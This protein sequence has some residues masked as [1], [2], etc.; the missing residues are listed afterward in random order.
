MILYRMKMSYSSQP[1]FDKE[2]Y[3]LVDI[4]DYN[5]IWKRCHLEKLTYT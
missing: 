2:I 4:D 3:T 5:T 1:W